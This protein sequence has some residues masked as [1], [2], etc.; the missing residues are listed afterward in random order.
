MKNS[1]L[2]ETCVFYFFNEYQLKIK[3]HKIHK[4][5]QKDFFIQNE[6]TNHEKLLKLN[7]TKIHFYLC[8]NTSELKITL[9]DE[10]DRYIHNKYTKNDNTILLQFENS[11]LIYFKNYLKALEPPKKYILTIINTYKHLLDSINLLVTNNIFHNQINFDSFVVDNSGYPL[12]SNF[13]FSIDYSRK[14]I[15]HYIKHFIIDYDPSYIEWP[16]ELHIISYLLTNKLNSLSNYNI[17]TIINEYINNN[18]IL[19][20]FGPSVV[21]SYKEEA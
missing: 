21:S 19:N 20:T 6:I 14:D 15:E 2:L 12:L 11:K 9:I 3:K 5:V 13:S 16:I 8:E 7:N 18:N 10:D 4:I 1:K 17:E